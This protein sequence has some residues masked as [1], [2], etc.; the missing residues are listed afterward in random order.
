MN[1][2]ERQLLQGLFDRL[3]DNSNQARD[4]EVER[5]ISDQIRALPG[6][7]YYMSQAII[8]QEQ[9]LQGSQERIAQL[10]DSV[11]Q[12]EAAG[13]ARGQNS[14]LAGRTGGMFG[15]GASAPEPS[16]PVS[17]VPATGGPWN[18][19]PAMAPQPQAQQGY[20]QPMQAQQPAASGGGGFLKGALATAAGVAGGALIYDQMKGMFGG[21]S[22]QA[23]ASSGQA[24]A[25]QAEVDRQLD[26]AQDEEMAEDT[27]ADQEFDSGGD[28]G[29][30][31]EI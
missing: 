31:T 15:R 27:A 16:R 5:F 28:S 19:G 9:A 30:D 10:E 14:F 8:V 29:G 25:N 1:Q 3:R 24:Q 23:H 13:Q 26:A 22:G 6:A 11:R 12:L 4:P 18:R 7:T 20:A 21:N 17:S 2:E